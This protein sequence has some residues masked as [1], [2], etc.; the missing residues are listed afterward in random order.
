[1]SPHSQKLYKALNLGPLWRLRAH[2]AAEQDVTQP[3]VESA[4]TSSPEPTRPKK[5]LSPIAPKAPE[6]VLPPS[7]LPADPGRLTRI[8]QLNAE[9]LVLEISQCQACP[10]HKTRK[11]AMPGTAPTHKLQYLV[12]DEAP[13]AQEEAGESVYTPP[14]GQ[15]LKAMLS[16]IGI[17]AEKEV[18]LT[19]AIKCR[20]PHNRLPQ[21]DELMQCAPF[22][23]RQ[24]ALLQPKFILALGRQASQSLLNQAPEALSA[25]R[26]RCHKAQDTPLIITYPP[27][28]LLRTPADKAKAWEDLCLL[29]RTANLSNKTE[30]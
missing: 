10:L 7:D 18:F 14:G 20:P 11:H 12:V 2:L 15:L 19:H 16:S 22:L 8:A 3:L 26:G 21:P 4:P 29:R 27:D 5:S 28:Y 6:A 23:A 30:S 13:H 1:M 17:D 25:L 24:I 9:E